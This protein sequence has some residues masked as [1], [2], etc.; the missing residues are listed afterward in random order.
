MNMTPSKTLKQLSA[1]LLLFFAIALFSPSALAEVTASTSSGVQTVTTGFSDVPRTHANYT[2]ITFLNDVKII[3]GYPDGTFKP[4]NPINRAEALKVILTG[5]G[6]EANEAFQSVFPDVTADQWFAPYV[7]KAKAMGFVQGNSTDGTFAPSRQVNLAEFLKMLL[8]AGG[9]SV[10]SFKGQTVVPN[11]PADAWYAP[12]VNY[13]ATLGIIYKDANGNVD[14]AKLLTRGE[15]ANILYLLTIIK[16]GKDTQFLLT[17][18]ETELAQIEIYIG[19]NQ[20]ALA[21]VASELAVDITQQAYKNMPDNAV[22]LGAAK[23]A[24]AYDYYMN[25]LITGIQG[26]NDEAA[27]WANQAIDKATEAW[28]ANNATQPIAKH[29][30]DRARDVLAQ[31]GGT[32]Q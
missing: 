1:I 12:Y 26:K 25:A 17:R 7:M 10:E 27:S 16:N 30:K 9:I 29:I 15:V 23:L 32:E 13:A 4:A 19:A 24:R 3:S 20:V 22:V 28:E 31:V 2:A 6:I 14:A 11:I 8:T 5:S 18:A 21:K